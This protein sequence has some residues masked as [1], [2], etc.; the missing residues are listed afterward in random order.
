MNILF[1]AHRVP[2]PPNKGD[3]LRA[4]NILR[5][6]SRKHKIW[7]AC[8]SETK[9]DLKYQNELK[10]YCQ[11]VDIV[12]TGFAC[13]KIKSMLYLF[14]NKPLTLPYFYSAKLYRKIK[15]YGLE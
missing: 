10:K 7:L 2:Y 3:K 8:I 9:Y 4:F 14:S 1:L 6:L 15:E 5:H 13:R 11:K 12:V